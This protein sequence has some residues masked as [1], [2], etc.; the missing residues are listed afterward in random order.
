MSHSIGLNVESL[1][2]L[3][4]ITIALMLGAISPGPAFIYVAKNSI[5]ISRKHGLYTA[6]GT[7]TGAAIFGLLAVMGL[8]SIVSFTNP[9]RQASLMGYT[10][11]RK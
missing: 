11:Y 7:G 9:L 1:L 6:L 8:K 5:A 10:L 3:F 2:P 4:S